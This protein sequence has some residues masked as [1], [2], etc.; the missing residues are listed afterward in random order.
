MLPPNPLAATL[1]GKAA[2]PAPASALP[3]SVT[4]QANGLPPNPLRGLVSPGVSPVSTPTTTPTPTPHAPTPPTHTLAPGGLEQAIQQTEKASAP[5]VAEFN[6]AAATHYS[7]IPVGWKAE[8]LR[9]IHEAAAKNPGVAAAWGSL[10]NPPEWGAQAVKGAQQLAHGVG[11]LAHGRLAH[12]ALDV[13]LGGLA[14]ASIFPFGRGAKAIEEATAAA[15]E[16]TAAESV[17]RETAAAAATHGRS[18]EEILA[19]PRSWVERDGG[20]FLTGDAAKE[21]DA[22]TGVRVE[23]NLAPQREAPR[24]GDAQPKAVSYTQSRIAGHLVDTEGKPVGENDWITLYHAT[25]PERAKEIQQQGFQVGG[26]VQ[27]E[28]TIIKDEAVARALGKKVG[29]TIGYEPG[30]G[31]GSG[32]YLAIDPRYVRHTYGEVVLPIRVKLSELSIPPERAGYANETPLKSLLLDDGYFDG[33]I[34]KD[35]IG[36]PFDPLNGEH[37]L[38]PTEPVVTHGAGEAAQPGRSILERPRFL[39]GGL[40]HRTQE[41]A[42]AHLAPLL[43]QAK[44][45]GWGGHI[46][47]EGNPPIVEHGVATPETGGELGRQVRE[48]LLHAPDVRNAQKPLHSLERGERAKTAEEAAKQAGGG[49][50]GHEAAKA[51]LKGRFGR[52]SFAH[53]QNLTS[54]QLNTLHHIVDES[55]LQ[56]YERVTAN[57][58]LTNAVKDGVA[59]TEGEQALLERVFGKVADSAAAAGKASKKELI[60]GG[61]NVTRAIR[62]AVDISASFR[63][64]LVTAVTHPAV[65]AKSFAKSARM[66]VDP[67]YHRAIMDEIHNDPFYPFLQKISNG[68]LFTEIG[69]TA[70]QGAN[71]A[72]REEA[73]IG[74]NLAERLNLREIPGP[75]KGKKYATGPG[76]LVRAS[77]RAF[78]GALNYTRFMVGKQLIEKAAL[79]GHDLSDP[80]VG[81]SIADLIGTITGRGKVPKFL[82]PHLVT[83]NVGLF[84]PRLIA[85]RLNML[86]P[87]YYAKLDPFARG[88]AL[89]AARNMVAM[90]GTVMVVAKMAGASVNFDPRSSNFGKIRFGNTRIDITGGF[91]Q[92]IRFIAQEMM[93]EEISSNGHHAHIGWGQHDISDWSNLSKFVRSKAAPIPSF[94]WDEMSGKDFIGRPIK[95]GHEL[96][97]NAPFLA[98]D[99]L[100]A[101]QTGAPPQRIAAAAFLSAI[102]FGVQSYKDKPQGR[103]TPKGQGAGLPPMPNLPALP[104]L[105]PLPTAGGAGK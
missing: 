64:N 31:A 104:A 54:D 67:A 50:A 39:G 61:L 84:S 18:K 87:V 46:G 76:D 11:E 29:D 44:A 57:D 102:G 85:A 12:G 17:A 68:K 62:S 65:F 95:Q 74:G 80:K 66:F 36:K 83:A 81:Q 40:E 101:Q 4:P 98:Q 14:A 19:D 78:T 52:E 88:E 1:G 20:R 48:S 8:D 99:I 86:S 22:V 21:L 45:E 16:A 3:P 60:I 15:R 7:D 55:P 82:E 59:P 90:M 103:P 63:Q 89:A 35:R 32:V 69:D 28:P 47:T 13:G 24:V 77:D 79:M 100:D 53:L 33:S 58:A 30:R 5:A 6:R 56:F 27:R 41:Q 70:K 38:A 97:G 92:Y 23:G 73:F 42:A 72:K 43:E 94:A 34:P 25:T 2:A 93:R 37:E 10:V 71:L 51:V 75:L 91:S 49:T 26:K 9:A 105:P 96:W